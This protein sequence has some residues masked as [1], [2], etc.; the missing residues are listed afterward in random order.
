MVSC[1]LM[2]SKLRDPGTAATGQWF[3]YE[4]WLAFW[5][6]KQAEGSQVTNSKGVV[7]PKRPYR[8]A[9]RV[10]STR[11]RNPEDIVMNNG[12]RVCASTCF[13][14]LITATPSQAATCSAHTRAHGREGEGEKGRCWR[15]GEQ[16]IM[17]LGRLKSS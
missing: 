13:M 9:T 17:I 1:L 7:S 6:L 5:I 16:D 2:S 14:V 12:C 8:E 15:H 11:R 3:M 10:W 4:S